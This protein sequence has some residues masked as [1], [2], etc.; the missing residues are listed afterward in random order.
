MEDIVVDFHG[1]TAASVSGKT[2]NSFNGI[3]AGSFS[4]DLLGFDTGVSTNVTASAANALTGST[5]GRLA[6]VDTLTQQ[7]NQQMS[8]VNDAAPS[9]NTYT[10]TFPSNIASMSVEVYLCSG[11]TEQTD[12]DG[13]ANGV[14]FTDFDS[15]NNTTGAT[16]TLAG[17][18]PNGSDQVVIFIENQ[19]VTNTFTAYNG[20]RFF[21]IV[22]AGLD[23][24]VPAG[25]ITLS[26]FAPTIVVDEDISINVPVGSITLTGFV[27]EVLGAGFVSDTFDGTG[28]L[29]SHWSVFDN[30][31]GGVT[32]VG[33]VSDYFEGT[34]SDNT[35][36]QTRWFNG[37]QGR[38]DYQTIKVPSSGVDEY[39]LT[40][41]GVGP[42]ANRLN[43]LPFLTNQ[44]SFCGIMVH[45]NTLATATSMFA[46]I[47]HRG[48]S[49]QATI[50]IKGTTAGTSDVTDEG[51]DVFTGTGV[52]HGDLAVEVDSSGVCKFKYRDLGGSTWTYI[53]SGTGLVP[54][55]FS[56]GSSGTDF[57][58]GIIGYASDVIGVPFKFTA[59]SMILADPNVS[60]NVPAGAITLSGLVP[61]VIAPNNLSVDVP[62]GA[63][64]L[65]GFQ[66]LVDVGSVEVNVNSGTITLTGH[67]PFIVN[68]GDLPPTA[69]GVVV[70]GDFGNGVI[71]ASKF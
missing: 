28:A 36:N 38:F 40:G 70:F 58:I 48:S 61:L 50:E 41:A 52:T 39:I 49:A 19:H 13:D 22:E 64:T 59:D 12:I 63:I 55:S 30:S 26:G 67:A 68:T 20:F 34:V 35:G 24:T 9:D 57:K 2:I 31:G 8:F 23:I 43:N 66:P 60:I 51:T 44:F 25:A 46:V 37:E 45:D 47:G 21:N 7:V 3:S 17:V 54:S 71:V 6:G 11:F 16:V 14:T 56:M 42:T 10:F 53:N 15:T 69:N 5:N 18:V 4:S 1:G 29:G 32:G 33:R 27:P 65:T 62:V